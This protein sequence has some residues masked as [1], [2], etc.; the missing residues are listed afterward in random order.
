MS[1]LFSVPSVVNL[2]LFLYSGFAKPP[3]ISTLRQ[4]PE[5]PKLP[6]I[7]EI[8]CSIQTF[9]TTAF[10]F[11]FFGNYQFWQ[12]VTLLLSLP[13]RTPAPPALRGQRSSPSLSTS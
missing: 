2:I 10:Q 11:G 9:F 5:L 6:N 8:S 3:S 4:L 12:L 13:A 7:A 1:V